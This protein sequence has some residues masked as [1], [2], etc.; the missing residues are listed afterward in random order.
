MA[1]GQRHHGC[2]GSGLRLL[3]G[4]ELGG[5]TRQGRQG[6]DL[7]AAPGGQ[8]ADPSPLPL[9][10]DLYLEGSDQHRGWFQSSWLTSVGPVNGQAPYKR[11]LTHGSPS[12]RR[13][14]LKQNP[15]EMWSSGRAETRDR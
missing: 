7:L 10:R 1:Q 13:S 4:G 9:P 8:G 14:Q 2:S 15:W 3:L 6:D 5:W 11:V 12:M